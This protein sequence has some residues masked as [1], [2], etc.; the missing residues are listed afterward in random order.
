MSLFAKRCSV[1]GKKLSDKCKFKGVC[2]PCGMD[3]TRIKQ[4]LFET[5]EIVESAKNPVTGFDRCIFGL[6]LSDDFERFVKAGLAK[7]PCGFG[8][9]DQKKFFVDAAVSFAKDIQQKNEK[10]KYSK[11]VGVHFI[12]E[13]KRLYHLSDSQVKPSSCMS[14]RKVNGELNGVGYCQDCISRA[15]SLS[16]SDFEKLAKAGRIPSDGLEDRYKAVAGGGVDV[17]N[18]YVGMKLD[19]AQAEEATASK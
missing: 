10:R 5:A 2:D 13:Y 14:C 12:P 7:F 11:K 16:L 17:F 6:G 19:L 4:Q 15:T 18:Q 9:E 8:L 3:F 1:C